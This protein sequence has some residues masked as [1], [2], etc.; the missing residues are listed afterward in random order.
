MCH[1]GYTSFHS[2]AEVGQHWSRTAL[3]DSFKQGTPPGG[4]WSCWCPSPEESL[5]LIWPITVGSKKNLSRNSTSRTIILL[6]QSGLEPPKGKHDDDSDSTIVAKVSPERPFWAR[7][8]WP[9]PEP[10]S[11]RPR[12]G[13]ASSR[14]VEIVSK[15]L[16]NSC[17]WRGQTQ[18]HFGTLFT[19]RNEYS[20]KKRTLCGPE[21][22]CEL[23][24][25]VFKWNI[26][27]KNITL[28]HKQ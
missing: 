13:E 7:P 6:H 18:L 14:P 8:A 10:L 15:K 27:Q 3:V 5:R 28:E 17:T 24:I 11:L 22:I 16:A 20:V 12:S 4:S 21:V 19:N 25:R 1:V 9:Y 2:Y 26:S 23:L